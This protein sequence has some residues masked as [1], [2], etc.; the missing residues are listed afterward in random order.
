MP[1]EQRQ[2][3]GRVR[4]CWPLPGHWTSYRQ[5]LEGMLASLPDE[6]VSRRSVADAWFEG[7]LVSSRSAAAPQLRFL[8]RLTLVELGSR[9]LEARRSELASHYLAEPSD[10]VVVQ[11]LQNQVYGVSEILD[12]LSDFQGSISMVLDELQLNYGV[13]WTSDWQVRF[14]LNWLRGFGAVR[15]LEAAE[16]LGRY[17]EWRLCE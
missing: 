4:S 9:P 12:C 11:L 13:T 17:P 6:F 1:A 15:Q 7:G 3:G 2:L 8:G 14:R 5:T 16:S 10:R